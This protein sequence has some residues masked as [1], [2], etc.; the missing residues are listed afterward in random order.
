V[1]SFDGLKASYSKA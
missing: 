1:L